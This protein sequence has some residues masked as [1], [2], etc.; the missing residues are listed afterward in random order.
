VGI[1]VQEDWVWSAGCQAG[2]WVPR[3]RS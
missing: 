3:W 2:G 1:R